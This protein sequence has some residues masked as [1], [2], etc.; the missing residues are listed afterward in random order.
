LVDWA[1]HGLT[2]FLSS[3]G[4]T[5]S[6]ANADLVTAWMHVLHK[7]EWVGLDYP[8]APDRLGELVG[9]VELAICGVEVRSVI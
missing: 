4:F 1:L 3:A 2:C 9:V 8:V 6:L 5:S 7:V